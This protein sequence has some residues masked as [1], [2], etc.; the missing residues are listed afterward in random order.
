MKTHIFPF[1]LHCL[2][3][4][5]LVPTIKNKSFYSTIFI[6]SYFISNCSFWCEFANVIIK[7]NIVF[8]KLS[9]SDRI[10]R[11]YF[12]RYWVGIFICPFNWKSICCSYTISKLSC[13]YFCINTC[14]GGKF[15]TYWNTVFNFNCTSWTIIL[16]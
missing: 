7:K 8:P 4:I 16:S 13:Y 5:L 1:D 3:N 10:Y 9:F 12:N 14:L 2:F 6:Y 15:V 11:I